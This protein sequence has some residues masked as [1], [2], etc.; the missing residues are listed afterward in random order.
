MAHRHALLVSL[1]IGFA[2]IVAALA[3][4]RVTQTG[5]ATAQS[6][7]TVSQTQIARRQQALDRVAASLR[8]ALARRP[9]KLPSLPHYRSIAP[10]VAPIATAA[11]PRIQYVRPSPI[12]IVKHRSHGDDG[13]ERD[14]EGGGD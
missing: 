7:G 2:A 12:V 8:R 9:P 1:L 14:S 6:T 3:L 5:S 13:G 10:S 4:A 11:P